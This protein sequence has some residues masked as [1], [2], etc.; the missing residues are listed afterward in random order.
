VRGGC[1]G[2]SRDH[3]RRGGLS[4]LDV[5]LGPLIIV[6]ADLIV[7]TL[8]GMLGKKSKGTGT[9]YEPFAG[10]ES[11]IPTRGLYQ[12][13]LFIFTTLFLVVEAF[14]LLLAGSFE[15]TTAFYP[16][17]FLAGGGGVVTIIVWWHL[18]VGGGEF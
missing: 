11:S 4:V 5:I 14:A 18:L 12:S 17:L 6:V 2:R 7:F 15:A 10:G 8:V 1:I 16:L 3:R 13:D 9:R